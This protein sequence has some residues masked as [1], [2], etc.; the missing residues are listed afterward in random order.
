MA[1][2]LPTALFVRSAGEF[3]GQLLGDVE[4]I[5]QGTPEALADPS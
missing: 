3:R 4:E 1:E 2:G 5:E